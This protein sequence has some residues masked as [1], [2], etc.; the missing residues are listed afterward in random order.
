MSS[1]DT[2]TEEG[3]AYA[4]K[5]IVNLT[6]RI[7]ECE[8][9]VPTDVYIKGC[10]RDLVHD[11]LRLDRRTLKKWKALLAAGEGGP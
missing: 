5:R 10:R 2:R 6:A 4:R 3:R 11:R 7:A 8:R 1:R 9:M